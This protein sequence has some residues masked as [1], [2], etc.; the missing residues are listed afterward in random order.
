[1]AH[2]RCCT[3]IHIIMHIGIMP[4]QTVL[5]QQQQSVE[6]TVFMVIVVGLSSNVYALVVIVTDTNVLSSY[7]KSKFFLFTFLFII[8][9]LLHSY[10][11]YLRDCVRGFSSVRIV[12]INS[13]TRLE[14]TA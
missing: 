6:Q 14:S 2:L 12:S 10:G 5:Q 11:C 7:Y 3:G 8:C 9:Y 1:M 4:A 13:S